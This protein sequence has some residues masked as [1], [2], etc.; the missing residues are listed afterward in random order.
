MSNYKVNKSESDAALR[1]LW[2][3]AEVAP[4]GEEEEEE[5]PEANPTPKAEANPAPKAEAN[6]APKPEADSTAD[7]KPMPL[8][9][10]QKLWKDAKENPT[11][12]QKQIQKSW[13]REQKIKIRE[14]KIKV[15]GFD[16][17]EIKRYRDFPTEV[18]PP[19]LRDLVQQAA[20]AMGCAEAFVAAPALT[21]V[22]AAIGTTR[23]LKLKDDWRVPPMI[24]TAMI[25][26]SGT[27]KSPPLKLARKPV[28][29]MEW[30]ADADRADKMRQYKEEKMCYEESVKNWREQNRKKST[31]PVPPPV[32]PT[33]PVYTRYFASDT[34]IEGLGRILN[35][36]PRGILVIRD[37]LNGWLGGMDQY[38]PGKGGDVAHYLEMYNG[39][40]MTVD[41]KGDDCPLKVRSAAVCISGGIQP[42]V[43]AKAIASDHRY[44][45]LTAR[46][47]I[48]WPPR[49]T[50]R[51]IDYTMDPDVEH[52]YGSMI[53]R[54]YLL[55]GAD[56]PLTG[57]TGLPV[58]IKLTPDAHEVMKDFVN[59]HGLQGDGL[60]HE[61]EE[62]KAAWSKLEEYPA[63]L[64]LGLHYAKWA[65]QPW[66]EQCDE[67]SQL[68]P[69]EEDVSAETMQAA[70]TLTEW[71][72]DEMLRVYSQLKEENLRAYYRELID[73]IYQKGGRI[74]ERQ[75]QQG[76]RS[77]QNA[78]A[79]E[80]ACQCIV[81][82]GHG[83]W[84]KKGKTRELVLHPA[85]SVY[86]SID[87]PQETAEV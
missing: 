27:L 76:R 20:K 4:E 10:L 17:R 18:L 69:F 77:I 50:R 81:E 74:T 49:P 31:E 37:E 82:D 29:E 34:T 16:S 11:P 66:P 51:W 7:E 70:V 24:W 48:C 84:E 2:A 57:E 79:A 55:Q 85:E 61:K 32:E 3:S 39:E 12:M 58:A 65:S 1:N 45:G 46:L 25:G 72:T 67:F 78:R 63:R 87:S 60:D 23:E 59:R 68:T 40:T 47:L 30:E 28:L 15:M 13:E 75:L 35:D 8:E 80:E 52:N 64:A 56:N 83:Y 22:A 38:K 86:A 6:P 41:R 21:V 62:V 53:K 36:N 71:F 33:P 73:W 43:F 42:Q 9:E 44:N 26:S 54:L 14:Q 19:V 5:E